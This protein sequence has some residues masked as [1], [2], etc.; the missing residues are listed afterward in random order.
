V[1]RGFEETTLTDVAAAAGIGRRTLFSYFPSKNDMVWGDFDS[2][3][4]RLRVQLAD[5]VDGEGTMGALGRAAVAS[6][7]YEGEALDELRMRMTLITTVPALQAHSMVRYGAWRRV[8]SEFVAAETGEEPDDLVPLT[9][10][11]MALATSMAAFVRWVHHPGEDLERHIDAGY[12]RLRHA[13]AEL[14]A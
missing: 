4:E 8:V 12:A 11:H 5:R 13:F 14:D 9:V 10:G 6:N 3:L 2:V 7:H 1:R